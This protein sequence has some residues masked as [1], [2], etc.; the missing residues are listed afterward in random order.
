MQLILTA[1]LV[2]VACGGTNPAPQQPVVETAS[3]AAEI[4]A[5]QA[6]L[7]LILHRDRANCPV[8]AAHLR[9]LFA[10]MTAS[11]ARANDLQKDP[12]VARQLTT[13]MKRY[14]A[15][16]AQRAVAIDAEVEGP[17]VHDAAVRDVLMTMPTL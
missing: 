15:A 13:D 17:C 4:D 10:Q 3:L 14:D 2:L 12:A 16:A 1:V 5:Q 8:L 6:D 7:A 9:A 11:F